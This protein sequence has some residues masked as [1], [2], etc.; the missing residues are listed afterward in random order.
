MKRWLYILLAALPLL[1]ACEQEE[2]SVALSIALIDAPCDGT[3]ETAT[4]T[5][6]RSWTASASD[7][8]I[9]VTPASGSKG[10]T[11]L[12]IQ[13]AANTGTSVRKGSVTVSCE[14]I[15]RS[16]TVNQVQ[17]LSQKLVFVHSHNLFVAP[18]LRGNGLFAE[19]DWGDGSAADWRSGVDHAYSAAGSHTVTMKLAGAT[20]FEKTDVT[21]ISEIDLSGF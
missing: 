9:S 19:I 21:G 17:P 3:Q 11:T 7:P 4:L 18:E 12:T 2:P 13:V 20:W 10:E 8:W 1:A 15:S 6:N 5:C 14:G 16:I